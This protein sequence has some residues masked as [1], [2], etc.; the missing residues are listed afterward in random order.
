MNKYY[1]L[2]AAMMMAVMTVGLTACGDDDD[3]EPT[4]QTY[5]ASK[6]IWTNNNRVFREHCC[7]GIHQGQ[8]NDLRVQQFLPQKL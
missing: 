2:L 6:P 1:S 5:R 3:D 4:P 7:Q 8:N